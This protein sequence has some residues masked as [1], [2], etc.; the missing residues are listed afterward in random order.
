MLGFN[1]CEDS[2]L[3]APLPTLYRRQEQLKR[4]AYEERVRQ[5]ERPSFVPLV[6][7][8]PG[9]ASPAATVVLKRLAARLAEA[10]LT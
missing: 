10:I 6:F 8:T 3:H 2:Y 7:T 1:L 5:V 4:N 9:S